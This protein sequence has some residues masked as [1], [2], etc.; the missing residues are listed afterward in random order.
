MQHFKLKIGSFHIRRI[1]L[2]AS[3]SVV[4]L[5]G[6]TQLLTQNNLQL[7]KAKA[8]VINTAGMQRTISQRI[9]KKMLLLEKENV[10]K[11]DLIRR[12]KELDQKWGNIHNKIKNAENGFGI[13]HGKKPQVDSLFRLI[14]SPKDKISLA[15]ASLH[16]DLGKEEIHTISSG[17]LGQEDVYLKLMNQIVMEYQLDL[18][19]SLQ[20]LSLLELLLSLVC[21]LIILVEFMLIFRPAFKS[22]NAQN[23]QLIAAYTEQEQLNK[24]LSNAQ[25]E[26]RQSMETLIDTNAELEYAINRAEQAAVAKAEFLST[27]SHEIRTPMNGVIGITHLLLEDN[28]K[29]SQEE[30]LN[31][32]KFSAENLLSLINDILDFSKIDAGKVELEKV[33]F[34]LSTLLEGIMYSL[35]IQAQEK[36]IALTFHI[37][38]HLPDIINTDPSRLTQILNNLLGNAIKFTKQGSVNL[39]ISKGETAEKGCYYNFEVIDT[40][41]GIPEDK[42]DSIFQTFSQANTSTSRMYGGSGLGLSITRKL[43]E[44]MGGSIEVQSEMHKGS[45][46]RFSVPFII[47][48]RQVESSEPDRTRQQ[49]LLRDYRILVA[50]DNRMNMLVI[51]QFLKKWQADFIIVENGLLAVNEAKENQYDLILMDLQMP[52]MDGLQACREIRKFNRDIPIIALTASATQEAQNE[53][54]EIGI[55]DFATKPFVPAELLNKIGRYLRQKHQ[56]SLKG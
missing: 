1:Y 19:E 2:F 28:P 38:P 12:I 30:N 48:E 53:A 46:F 29:P 13:P 18:Q 55:N 39:K 40:G 14:Q 45:C 11:A 35:N 7:Q 33:D 44:L 15:I 36:N 54:V 34:S 24:E 56:N 6:G 51:S 9:S 16:K 32:L 17:V 23:T 3:I 41:I 10:D 52:V 50:E 37:D 27:M 21:I 31:S 47:H 22:L 43:L 42:L 4:F 8:E 20:E 25:E 49:F 26:L 5:I